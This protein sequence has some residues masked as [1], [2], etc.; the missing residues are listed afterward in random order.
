MCRILLYAVAHDQPTCRRHTCIY[1]EYIT[2]ILLMH[3]HKVYA[4]FKPHT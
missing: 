2:G 4:L 3:A 1:I